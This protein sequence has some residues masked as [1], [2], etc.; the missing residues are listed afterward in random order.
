M[1][2]A[3]AE[4]NLVADRIGE[5]IYRWSSESELQLLLLEVLKPFHPV[6]E[7]RLSAADRIDFLVGNVGVEVKVAG[8]VKSVRRQLARYAMSAEVDSL[9]LVTA[10]VR[11]LELEGF[12]RNKPVVV[13][14]VVAL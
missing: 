13:V 2:I 11:H 5:H 3:L 6:R 9:V 8:A 4:A 1:V 12:I 14:P 7:Y 10:K